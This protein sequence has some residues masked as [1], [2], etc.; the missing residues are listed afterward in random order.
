M[1]AARP[2]SYGHAQ[3][4]ERPDPPGA[5]VRRLGASVRYLLA[6]RREFECE[7]AGRWVAVFDECVISVNDDLARMTAHLLDEGYPSGQ[8]VVQHLV[9][10]GALL[11]V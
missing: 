9:P 1:C 11:V 7:F 6:A 10:H 2:Q 8:V 5:E 3:V 4:L